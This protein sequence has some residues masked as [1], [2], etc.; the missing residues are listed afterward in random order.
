MIIFF[1]LGV[2]LKYYGVEIEA[3]KMKKAERVTAILPIRSQSQ[4]IKNKNTRLIADRPLYSYVINTLKQV[5]AIDQIVVST[6][7]DELHDVFLDDSRIKVLQRAPHLTGN[8][9]VNLVIGDVL[10]SVE[11]ECFLQTHV[12][13]PLLTAESIK[14]ALSA[15]FGGAPIYD[16]VFSATKVQKRFWDGNGRRLNHGL[17]DEPTTQTLEPWFEEN[18]CIYVFSRASFFRHYHRIGLN[19]LVFPI[20]KIEAVDIDD[21]EDFEIARRLIESQ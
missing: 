11:G 3:V 10:D 12:T 13:N 6:D 4:R 2:R 7:Y 21:E 16:S 5:K 1:A 19:P 15:F 17:G 8:C 14:Q 20:P 9:D 18:S